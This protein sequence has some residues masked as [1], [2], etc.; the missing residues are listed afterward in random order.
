MIRARLLNVR[1][2]CAE[3][4]LDVETPLGLMERSGGSSAMAGT[5]DRSERS[6]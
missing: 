6:S 3:F 4:G 2:R 1:Q 5:R